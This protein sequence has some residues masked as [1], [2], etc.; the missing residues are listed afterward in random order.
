MCTKSRLH[1]QQPS[2]SLM[3]YYTKDQTGVTSS[4]VTSASTRILFHT[5]AVVRAPSQMN[6]ELFS[7]AFKGTTAVER[8]HAAE[9][10]SKPQASPVF[11]RITNARS[12]QLALEG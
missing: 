10:R 12:L 4:P 11:R 8:D 6:P 1:S 9:P 3:N 2:V 7:W 5:K